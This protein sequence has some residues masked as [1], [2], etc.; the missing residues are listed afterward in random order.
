MKMTKRNHINALVAIC[1]ASMV[2]L[3]F[4]IGSGTAWWAGVATIAAGLTFKM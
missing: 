3:S 1:G 2:A 4:L